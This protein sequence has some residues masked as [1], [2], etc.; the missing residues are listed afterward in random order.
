MIMIT[1]EPGM[2]IKTDLSIRD[3]IQLMPNI[4]ILK[5]KYVSGSEI[6]LRHGLGIIMATKVSGWVSF[7]FSVPKV[8][9]C[10]WGVK[11]YKSNYFKNFFTICFN[12][13]NNPVYDN[14]SPFLFLSIFSPCIRLRFNT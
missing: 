14:G 6:I 9:R 7:T 1:L 5:N 8:C 2:K 3:V 11:R 12:L 4:N 13:Q 10:A